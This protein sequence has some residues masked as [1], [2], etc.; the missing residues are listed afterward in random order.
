MDDLG[1]QEL[2]SVQIHP[3]AANKACAPLHLRAVDLLGHFIRI[4]GNQGLLGGLKSILIF[5][6][7]WDTKMTNMSRLKWFKTM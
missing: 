4:E 1:A 3:E 2:P 7:F 6:P 5:Y